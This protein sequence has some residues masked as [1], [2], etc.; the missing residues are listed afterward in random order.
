LMTGDHDGRVNPFHSRKMIARLQAAN[1]SK[2][3]ILLRTT[4]SAGHGMGTALD[5]R[6]A[7]EADAFAFLFDQLGMKYRTSSR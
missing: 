6:I 5:E 1:A 4:S 7:Q 2:N 3:P